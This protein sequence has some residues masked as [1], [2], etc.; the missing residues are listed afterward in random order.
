MI[1]PRINCGRL[2][3]H[4]HFEPSRYYIPWTRILSTSRLMFIMKFYFYIF[5]FALLW[6]SVSLP[7]LSFPS[8][9]N[10]CE[11]IVLVMSAHGAPPQGGLLIYILWCCS[12]CQD[13]I[14]ESSAFNIYKREFLII[15]STIPQ[16]FY[17]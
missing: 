11:W 7:S 6:W 12:F 13:I 16:I 4:L 3:H 10:Y 8:R 9:L 17:H 14:T 2:S 15:L 1:Y 5:C